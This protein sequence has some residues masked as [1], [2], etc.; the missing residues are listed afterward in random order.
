MG[1]A[2]LVMRFL[3]SCIEGK[4]TFEDEIQPLEVSLISSGPSCQRGCASTI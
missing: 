2:L 1:G 4:V 3:L